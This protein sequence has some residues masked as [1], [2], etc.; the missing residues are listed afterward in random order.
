MRR[1]T[2]LLIFFTWFVSAASPQEQWKHK[3][4]IFNAPGTVALM[5]SARATDSIPAAAPACRNRY[6]FQT[7]DVPFGQPGIDLDMQA[8]Y[9]SDSGIVAVQYQIPPSGTCCGAPGFT[10][11]DHTAVL[12]SGTWTNIDVPGAVSTL[13]SNPD[14][15]GNVALS[16]KFADGVWH[17][18]IRN[19]R[20]LT[21]FP[22]PPGYPGGIQASGINNRGEVAALLLDAAG[23][24]HGYVGD[25]K[26]YS[27][28]DYPGAT[29]TYFTKVADTGVVVGYYGLAD[30]SL[31]AFWYNDGHFRKI[32]PP[33]AAASG[34]AVALSINNAG[35]IAGAYFNANGW[36]V[37]FLLEKG[38]FVD[39][40]VQ[41]APL[42]VPW[43]INNRGEIA[44][45]YAG[46][47]GIYHG[48][49][50]KPNP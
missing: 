26:R 47:D 20:G 14:E 11:N 32:D 2:I 4:T 37:G 7:I 39:F 35:D 10:E 8:L 5:T 15:Q 45:I 9:R 18:A 12:R 33:G 27:V 30:G 21:T 46:A 19:K 34:V 44:G 38:R 3:N 43:S 31:H 23:H 50:A 6:F 36:L 41:D 28:L 22:E 16:Y 13:A 48:F 24:A 25:G 49:V 40:R 29:D 42:T 17:V 1:I